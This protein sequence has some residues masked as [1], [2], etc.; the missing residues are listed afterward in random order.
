MHAANPNRDRVAEVEQR[1]SVPRGALRQDRIEDAVAP[2]AP[3]DADQ[4]L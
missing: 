2:L 3:I 1:H 4:D